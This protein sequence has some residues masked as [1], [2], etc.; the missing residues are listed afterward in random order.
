MSS[1]TSGGRSHHDGRPNSLL[2]LADALLAAAA[3]EPLDRAERLVDLGEVAPGIIKAARGGAYQEEMARTGETPREL[4]KRI[5][6]HRS[7]IYDA[8]HKAR[9]AAAD[10][11][12]DAS[13]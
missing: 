1:T 5:A 11:D 7:R 2:G 6:L 8:V 3:A 4:A 12:P 9:A 13:D 10:A